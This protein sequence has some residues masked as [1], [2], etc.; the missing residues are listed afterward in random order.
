MLIELGL[1]ARAASLRLGL[2]STGHAN[3]EDGQD[4]R[5]TGLSP[6]MSTG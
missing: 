6:A 5:D 2:A 1:H 4:G 3:Q